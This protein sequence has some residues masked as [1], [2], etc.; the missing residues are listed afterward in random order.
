MATT[1][2]SAKQ[3]RKNKASGASGPG[4]PWTGHAPRRLRQE[5]EGEASNEGWTLWRKHLAKR[6]GRPISKLFK[7]RSSPLF[8]ALPPGTDAA[9]AEQIIE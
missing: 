3:S 7:G 9:Q 2:S 8:W 1:T 5:Y 6:K 4:G